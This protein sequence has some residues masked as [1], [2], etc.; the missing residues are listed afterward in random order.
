M[1]ILDR[2]KMTDERE[3]KNHLFRFNGPYDFTDLAKNIIPNSPDDYGVVYGLASK[4]GYVRVRLLSRETDHV[5]NVPLHIIDISTAIRG[6]MNFNYK[7]LRTFNPTDINTEKLM[8]REHVQG[9]TGT[10]F[11]LQKHVEV[12]LTGVVQYKNRIPELERYINYLGT[13][14][15]IEHTVQSFIYNINK[16]SNDLVR[17]LSKKDFTIND[18]EIATKEYG[19]ET[20][21]IFDKS[22]VQGV[23]II[24]YRDFDPSDFE[25]ARL[26]GVVKDSEGGVLLGFGDHA[27]YVGQ[28]VNMA[29][30]LGSHR[31]DMYNSSKKGYGG[32][33]YYVA[34]RAKKWSARRLLNQYDAEGGNAVQAGLLLDIYENVFIVLL[35]AYHNGVLN[36]NTETRTGV[37]NVEDAITKDYSRK[38]RCLLFDDLATATSRQTGYADPKDP[39]RHNAF[40]VKT[41][42]NASS[43]MT[44]G[45]H[46][47]YSKRIW[48]LIRKPEINRLEFHRSALIAGSASKQMTLFDLSYKESYTTIATFRIQRP[49]G[50]DFPSPGD[51]F[52]AVWEV[53]TR[54]SHPVPYFR[55]QNIGCWSN[56]GYA[57]RLAFKIVW[58][59]KKT[60]KWR[61]KYLQSAGKLRSHD[62]KRAGSLADYCW[63]VAIY[64]Y[65]MRS[66]WPERQSFVPNFGLAHVVEVTVN[67]F[68]QTAHCVPV[69]EPLQE[70]KGPNYEFS[71]AVATMKRLTVQVGT[72]TQRLQNVN[73]PW[74]SLSFEWVEGHTQRYIDNAKA[75]GSTAESARDEL[76]RLKKRTMCDSCW[77]QH[78]SSKAGGQVQCT[79]VKKSDGTLMNWCEPCRLKGIACSWTRTDW[80]GGD[81]FDEL[82]PGKAPSNPQCRPLRGA[83]HDLLLKAVLKQ[84][85]AID[86]ATATYETRDPDYKK[87]VGTA[88]EGDDDD[89]D[90]GGERQADASKGKKRKEPAKK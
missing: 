89:A 71:L 54:G 19:N 62:A 73:G 4:Q 50:D 45:E 83:F 72:V 87:V 76:S 21:G 51:E 10:H 58:K 3:I 68:E 43:P 17:V 48:S 77:L 70:L 74:Q 52:Y 2:D 6:D 22:L 29:V 7:Q 28:S 8:T 9:G 79:Q 20:Q 41:G 44:E 40:G 61:T 1:A 26:D 14:K 38:E 24:I 59:S 69:T 15:K 11:S 65:L 32:T 82:L 85:R 23:Y 81:G 47:L 42:L 16:A 64:A 84:P 33:H 55:I 37:E 67:Q 36:W 49:P 75:A 34:R 5:G 53:S 25:H 30:R 78:N 31:Y 86:A 88:E 39:D 18:V 80:L 35:R 12:F 66:A 46:E 27:I 63:G 60:G 90:D 57:L 13:Q 56:W